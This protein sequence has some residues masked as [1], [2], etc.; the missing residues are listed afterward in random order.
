MIE[1]QSPEGADPFTLY[2]SGHHN[3]PKEQVLSPF[4]LLGS[5]HNLPKEQVL[6]PFILLGS[7]HNLPKEQVLSP[8]IL[9]LLLHKWSFWPVGADG[10]VFGTPSASTQVGSDY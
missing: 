4:I 5:H 10:V 1:P 6:S 9:L 7:H 2:S 3:L 8:F